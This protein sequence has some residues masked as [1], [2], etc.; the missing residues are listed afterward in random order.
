MRQSDDGWVRNWPGWMGSV[1]EFQISYF[2]PV[3]TGPYI[4]TKAITEL[5]D[6]GDAVGLNSWRTEEGAALLEVSR[7]VKINN[8]GIY[9]GHL[10]DRSMFFWMQ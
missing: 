4:Q 3:M 5:W 9:R 1:G 7:L 6:W 10:G 2:M 8:G